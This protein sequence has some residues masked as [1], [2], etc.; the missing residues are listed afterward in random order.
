MYTVHVVCVLLSVLM[1]ISVYSYDFL[2]A[3]LYAY[4]NNGKLK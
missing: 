2:V 4:N 1:V 3:S